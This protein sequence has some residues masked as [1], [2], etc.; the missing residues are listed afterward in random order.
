MVG[1]VG[2]SVG[3]VDRVSGWMDGEGGGGT[4]AWKAPVR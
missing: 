1:V 3:L 2:K 4:D